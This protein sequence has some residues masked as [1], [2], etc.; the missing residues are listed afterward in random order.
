MKINFHSQLLHLF[1]SCHSFSSNP[2]SNDN[3]KKSPSTMITQF[4]ALSSPL[5]QFVHFLT[6][7]TIRKDTVLLRFENYIEAYEGGRT[8]EINLLG[9]FKYFTITSMTEMNLSANQFLKDKKRWEWN[10]NETQF[11]G[12]YHRPI[13]EKKNNEMTISLKPME[14][15]TFIA[16]IKQKN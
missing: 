4:S 8:E 11:H 6:M 12:D 14:I 13:S 2:N 16:N 1:L 7:E 9:L 15:R 5:P 10:T 3:E